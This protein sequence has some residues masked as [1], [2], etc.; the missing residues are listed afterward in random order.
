[1]VGE[2]ERELP[3]ASPLG[4]RPVRLRELAH[5]P[6][7]R[8]LLTSKG[9]DAAESGCALEENGQLRGPMQRD[10]TGRAAC[11]DAHSVRWDVKS[12]HSHHPPSKGGVRAERLPEQN[13]TR[14]GAR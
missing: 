4:E 5:D 1:V 12:F 11:I 7:Y 3:E 13:G 9:L 2:G 10:A 8:H 14:V 6:A